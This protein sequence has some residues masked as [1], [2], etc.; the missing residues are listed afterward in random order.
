MAK[1][2]SKLKIVNDNTEYLFKDLQ[3]RNNISSLLGSG[4]LTNQTQNT[5]F[6]APSNKDGVPQFR[7]ITAS[8]LPILNQDTTGIASY[9]KY[10]RGRQSDGT[11]YGSEAGNNIIAEWN[12]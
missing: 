11:Y 7:K 6:A 2:V 10:L 3:A 5:F 4:I 12:T 1:D 9:A 8:D